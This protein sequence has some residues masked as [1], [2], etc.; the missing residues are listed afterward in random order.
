MILYQHALPSNNFVHFFFTLVKPPIFHV[1]NFVSEILL[2][3]LAGWF[4]LHMHFF[5]KQP[6]ELIAVKGTTPQGS[7]QVGS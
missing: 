5:P 4:G 3:S 7:T 6:G 1:L 2:K